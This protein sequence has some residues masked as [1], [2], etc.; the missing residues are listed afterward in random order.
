MGGS[1]FSPWSVLKMMR[2][3]QQA[4]ETGE[5]E[6]AKCERMIA[7]HFARSLFVCMV[8]VNSYYVQ[9][10]TLQAFSEMVLAV[11]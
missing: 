3:L 10:Q 1:R 5:F 9:P 4:I 2:F 6:R 11:P 8:G 7:L